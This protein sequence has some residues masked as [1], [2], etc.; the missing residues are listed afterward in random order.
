M[1]RTAVSASIVLALCCAVGWMAPAR[2]VCLSPGQLYDV[3]VAGHSATFDLSFDGDERYLLIVANLAR[4]PQPKSV[5]LRAEARDGVELANF[6]SLA[7]LASKALTPCVPAERMLAE[8]PAA[9]TTTFASGPERTF[10]LHVGPGSSDNPVTYRPIVARLAAIGPHVAVYVDCDDAVEA[11]DARTMVNR[12]EQA[13]LPAVAAH[14]GMPADVD[15]DG[16]LAILLTSWLGRLDGGGVS[17]GGMVWS[18]DF[19]HGALPPFSNGADV[20][21]LNAG[22]RTGPHLETLLAHELAHAITASGRLGGNPAQ[23][24]RE[25][26]ESWLN[27]AISHVAENLHSDNWSNLDYRIDAFLAATQSTPLVVASYQEHGLWRCPAARGC[28]YLFLRWSVDRYGPGLLSH[29]IYS[30]KCGVKNLEAATGASF[31]ELLRRWAIDMF[32]RPNQHG[33]SGLPVADASEVP[34]PEIL[35][36]AQYPGSI[37]PRHESWNV[38]QPET[39]PE[40][41]LA[42]TSFQYVVLSASQPG[43]RRIHA[44]TETGARLQLT[45][46]RL[47]DRDGAV[48]QR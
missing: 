31:D 20:L 36:A 39:S 2:P 45:L 37:R 43:V 35:D 6:R 47:D 38:V 13:V 28:T 24:P 41:Q 9:E 1:A 22:I 12:F 5:T 15:G 18:D 34:R 23:P 14:L 32:L 33:H 40:L 46:I 26:E 25:E 8:A 44:A 3:A 4:E 7:P 21:Y 16:H 27:E 30:P 10:W 29:L 17:L 48:R 42:G 19:R 11:E